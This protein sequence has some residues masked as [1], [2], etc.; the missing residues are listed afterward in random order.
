ML[1]EKE[2]YFI[3]NNKVNSLKISS[4]S[5]GECDEELN[6]DEKNDDGTDE[7]NPNFV[8]ALQRKLNK[9]IN[10]LKGI[11]NDMNEEEC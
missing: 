6:V 11:F 9:N 3:S 1:D 7:G 5:Y 10:D 4:G 2:Q 8:G